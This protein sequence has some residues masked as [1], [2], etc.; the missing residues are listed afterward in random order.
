MSRGKIKGLRSY[1]KTS[2]LYADLSPCSRHPREGGDPVIFEDG[3]LAGVFSQ[4]VPE[5]QT[6]VN[7]LFASREKIKELIN[8]ERL[9]CTSYTCI[10]KALAELEFEAENKG[11]A[12]TYFAMGYLHSMGIQFPNDRH[13]PAF[14]F[15]KAAELGHDHAQ[16]NLNIIEGN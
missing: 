14:W 5:G 15:S 6:G 13:S 11:D 9:S 10:R 7:I 4:V 16:S 3:M 8:K 1:F 12:E 2:L